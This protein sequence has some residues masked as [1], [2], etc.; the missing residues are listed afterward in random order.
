MSSAVARPMRSSSKKLTSST[1]AFSLKVR[2]GR[3]RRGTLA[4]HLLDRR[5]LSPTQ[6]DAKLLG[7]PED[8]LVGL[9]HLDLHAVAG[10]HLDVEAQRLHLLDEHLEGLRNAGL[11]DVLALDDRLVDLHATEH[12]VGLDGE[13][14]LQRIS[15]AVGL[16]RPHL[17]LA[18]PL[19]AELGLTA[20]RLL[21]DHRVGAGRP[22]VDLVVDQVEQLQDVDVAHADRLAERLTAAAVVELGLAFAADELYAVAVGQGRAEQ[23]CDLLLAGAVEDRRREVG[24]R[25]GGVGADLGEPLLPGFLRPVDLP[26][27][28]GHPAEVRLE[29]L[30]DIHPA[31]HTER[32]EDD[33]DRRAVLE[34]RHVLDRQ[35][36][37]DDALVAVAAGELVTVGDLALLRDVDAHQLV[38]TRGQL[39]AVV[40]VEH[41]YADDLALFA[42]RH[43]QRRVA[44]LARLLTE[45]GAEQPLLRRQLGLAL[46]RDLADEDV[47]RNDLGTDADDAALVEVGEDLLGDVRDVPGDLLGAQLGVA[48]V[49]L[50]LLDVDRGQDVVLHQALREDDRVL[51]VV[52]LPAHEGD[53]QVLAERH[54]TVVGAGPIGDDLAGQHPVAVVDDR[55]LVDAGALV[56]APELG[57][58][59]GPPRPVVVHDGDE[60][61]G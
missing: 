32:V 19:A 7:G 46:G 1:Y 52:P 28:L 21:R 16:E 22:G 49:D 51:V 54:L 20:Q 57:E 17:H 39:V 33:V 12:V 44:D 45:D 24:A 53:Q 2:C 26:A 59:V 61:G 31:G 9:A 29:D 13:Q 18:E 4:L 41:P 11:R 23:P 58:P 43:L 56:G 47:A 37:G 42:V 5:R 60:V 27:G 30:A 6:I 25:V 35:H 8:V 3:V 48:G 10:K 50:V 36:L 38:D 14:L 40:T 34:E 55:P 15:R